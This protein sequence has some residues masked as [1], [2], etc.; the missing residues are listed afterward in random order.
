MQWVMRQ[1]ISVISSYTL[2]TLIFN[3]Y[4]CTVHLDNVKIP[5]TNKCT[6]Y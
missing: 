1:D 6:F 5:F 2:C 3:F 4:R